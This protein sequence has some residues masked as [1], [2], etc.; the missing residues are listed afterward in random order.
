MRVPNQVEQATLF[1]SR[2]F[3][4]HAMVRDYHEEEIP[5]VYNLDDIPS[6]N[7]R[8]GL[9]LHIFRG[10]DILLSMATIEP[11]ANLETNPHTHPWEQLTY[12]V[13]GEVYYHIG[14]DRIHVA[15]GDFFFIPPN[16]QH[17]AEPDPDCDE[18]VLN[19]DVFPMRE[20]YAPHAQYQKEF[21]EYETD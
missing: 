7:I 4:V 21:V 2:I 20:D 15:E 16:V 19:L 3:S 11:D 1:L 17:Y 14:D 10:L 9:D 12:I 8:E 18:T 5:S 6:Y 13:N